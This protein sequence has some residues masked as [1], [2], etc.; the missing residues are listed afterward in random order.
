M[1]IGN[2]ICI[3]Q[4]IWNLNKLFEL[5]ESKGWSSYDQ[6]IGVI[7]NFNYLLIISRRTGGWNSK[8]NE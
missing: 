8:M 3:Y 2:V 5:K 4:K 7:G 6:I 1:K